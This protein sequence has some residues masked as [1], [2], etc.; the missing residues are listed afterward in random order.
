MTG[1][2]AGNH[3]VIESTYSANLLSAFCREW[4]SK[5]FPYNQSGKHPAQPFPGFSLLHTASP[6]L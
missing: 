6:S 3:L 1:L 2:T 4:F 5:L